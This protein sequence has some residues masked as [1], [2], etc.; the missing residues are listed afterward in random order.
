MCK[1]NPFYAFVLMSFVWASAYAQQEPL[2]C[3]NSE[4]IKRV[5]EKNGL[6]HQDYEAHF[7]RLIAKRRQEQPI[8]G[9]VADEEEVLTLPV[10]FH[11]LID[12]F[13]KDKRDEW[14][15]YVPDQQFKDQVDTLNVH[16]RHQNKNKS[17]IL[18]SFRA[19]GADTKIEF[20]LAKRDPDGL[21]T[22]GILRG[23]EEIGFIPAEYAS[24][25]AP[26]LWEILPSLPTW[27]PIWDPERY[28]NIYVLPQANTGGFGG[29]GI[30]P[31]GSLDGLATSVHVEEGRGIGAVN[32][33]PPIVVL[34]TTGVSGELNEAVGAIEKGYLLVHEI[35]HFLS[36]WHTFG[37]SDK[38][39]FLD[40]DLTIPNPRTDDY[41]DD[42]PYHRIPQGKGGEYALIACNKITEDNPLS[43]TCG[44]LDMVQNY[45]NYSNSSCY[46]QFSPCQK[47]RMRTVLNESYQRKGLTNS[48]LALTAPVASGT[49]NLKVLKTQAP[50]N[51]CAS[52]YDLSVIVA[53]LGTNTLATY[54]V[55]AY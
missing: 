39:N 29:A 4:Y 8:N 16:F 17:E 27:S 40:D 43:T 36:L 1:F 31:V 13:N 28:L 38:C 14:E 25:R 33:E 50:A 12:E 6:T 26:N 47:E 5:L 48:S 10:V 23:G 9:W 3:G 15:E 53:N 24:P 19:L 30:F 2:R 11:V 22:D 46:R 18:P 42:T 21:P 54:E 32:D 7:Q 37:D 49:D 20:G 35:G 44:S 41:C 34:N 51:I 55:G 45:M 52:T